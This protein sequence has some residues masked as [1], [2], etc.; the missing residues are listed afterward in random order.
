MIN[1]KTVNKRA[2]LAI[3]LAL[4]AFPGS[5]GAQAQE[6]HMEFVTTGVS[7]TVMTL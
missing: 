3:S 2:H 6:F 1:E 7:V 4:A 5:A